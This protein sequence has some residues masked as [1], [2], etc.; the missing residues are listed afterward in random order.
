MILTLPAFT[1]GGAIPAEYAYCIPGNGKNRKQMGKNLNPEMCWSDLPEGAQSLAIIMVDKDVPQ[2]K[3]NANKEGVTLTKDIARENFYHFVLVDIPVSLSSIKE[4][5]DSHGVVPQGKKPGLTNYGIRGINDYS[6]NNG[7]YDGPCP[8][9]NDE[10]IHHYHFYLYALDVK[11]LGLTGH[12][13]GR[14]TL[15]AIKNHI[16]AQ[17]EWVGTYSLYQP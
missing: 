11:S 3:E 13:D 2:N 16:L 4:G 14:Q 6:P 8:P 7:G 17:S 15:S 5:Q 12:F 1:N 9:W 10:L